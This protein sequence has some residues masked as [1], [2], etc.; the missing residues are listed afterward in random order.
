MDGAT[1][2]GL[3]RMLLQPASEQVA[4][5]EATLR[6]AFS[7]PMFICDLFEQI[8]LSPTAEVRQLAAVLTRRRVIAHWPKLDEQTQQQLQATL[9]DRLGNE[10]EHAV[11]RS[12]SSVASVIGRHA[13][14]K[15]KWPELFAFLSQ[16][17]Q[18]AAEVHRELAMV[19]LAS[20]LES[21]AV[22]E[23][24]L[25]P[26]FAQVRAVIQ[27]ALSDTGSASLA[28]PRAALKAVSAWAQAALDDEDMLQL[29]PLIPPVLQAGVA[30]ATAGEEDMLVL[31]LGIFTDLLE[32]G[33]P[34]VDDQIPAVLN[35]ALE[36]STA[37]S[38]ETE[39]R[40][41]ALNLVAV[42]LATRR[43]LLCK[44]KLV[45]HVAAALFKAC[46]MTA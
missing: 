38:L 41:C 19:L 36:A 31:A 7:K 29:G 13:L 14:P 11:R 23:A 6:K 3:L 40:T 24:C 17:A 26:H 9:L 46:T 2:E 39:S 45:G 8:Q 15:G 16:C 22:V 33:S 5:A 20:L 1:L 30:A 44:Q 21:D 27:Q 18:S 12:L 10:P 35:F 37:A 34:V 28:V 42:M 43:K 32:A 4:Q 25:R